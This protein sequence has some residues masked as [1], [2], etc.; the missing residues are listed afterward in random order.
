MFRDFKG[1]TDWPDC[2][3]LLD[4]FEVAGFEA[5]HEA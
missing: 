5:V 3:T 2:L 1:S 4:T